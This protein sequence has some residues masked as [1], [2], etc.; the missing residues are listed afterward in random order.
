M[1]RHSFAT[2]VQMPTALFLLGVTLVLLTTP[3]A[4]V[5]GADQY[6]DINNP[7]GLPDI[8]Q[9]QNNNAIPGGICA[10]ATMSN[11]MWDLS[12]A[13]SVGARTLVNHPP[14]RNPPENWPMP[15]A[16]WS[17]NSLALR[18]SL[19]W[20]IYGNGLQDGNPAK[21]NGHGTE[22]GTV[23]YLAWRG[24]LYN[25][26]TNPNGLS[27]RTYNKG[28]ATYQTLYSLVLG[29][30][31]VAIDENVAAHI[32]WH[33]ADGT[34]VMNGDPPNCPC[35][36][37]HSLG[38]AGVNYPSQGDPG[39]QHIYFTNGW[40]SEQMLDDPVNASYYDLYNNIIIDN[41]AGN[42][43][44]NRFRIPAG[45][46]ANGPARL[47]LNMNNDLVRG[48]DN[49]DNSDY[50]EMYQIAVV[51]PGG[52]PEVGVEL[53]LAGSQNEF[54][55]SVYNPELV[56]MEHFFLEIGPDVLSGLKSLTN[57][58]SAGLERR[59]LGPCRHDQQSGQLAGPNGRPRRRSR[60]LRPAIR[61]P[62]WR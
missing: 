26:S 61:C 47:G 19:V 31:N 57:R 25:S 51:K 62:R 39:N 18:G 42:N 23:M 36:S 5:Q 60:S 24:Y 2:A 20:A 56:P 46:A 53:H 8:T 7:T 27:V 12:D 1:R 14:S 49:S 41:S 29:A 17:A 21:V 9:N 34:V 40:G 45:A 35:K 28:D 32:F 4:Q 16:N 52:S 6:V 3:V 15:F 13:H 44:N 33:N 11:F 22:A 48:I 55:Y 54:R 37:R 59:V 10:A 30:N 58:G 50:V 38:V 43:P